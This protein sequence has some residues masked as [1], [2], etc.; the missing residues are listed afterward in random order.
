MTG[1]EKIK[2]KILEDAE[3]RAGQIIK[4]AEAEARE[5]KENALKEAERKKA[6]I[7]KKGETDGKEIYRRMLSEADLEGRKEVLRTKQDLVEEAF[8]KAMDRLCGISDRDYQN[9]LVNM[10]VEAAKGE[11]GE[12]LLSEA[13]KKRIDKD[14]V[15]NIN[16]KIKD[17]GKEGK[18]VLAEDSIRTAGGFVLRYKDMEINNTFEVLFEMLKPRLENDVVKILF[19]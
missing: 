5:I 2:A 12:I 13:D 8:R 15:K 16:R 18:L 3:A 11:D 9:L 14:F 17:C 10:I 4:E 19:S 6:E 7:L 1:T